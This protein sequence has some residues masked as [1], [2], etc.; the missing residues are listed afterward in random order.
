MNDIYRFRYKFV[1]VA[2][3]LRVSRKSREISPNDT[4]ERLF[5]HAIIGDYEFDVDRISMC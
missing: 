2:P 5:Y 3:E 1:D 4:Q